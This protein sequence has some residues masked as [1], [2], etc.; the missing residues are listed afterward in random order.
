[1]NIVS[2]QYITI[3]GCEI[4]YRD[5]G[6]TGPVVLLT[7]GIGASLETWEAMLA[8]A[9]ESIRWIS[10]DIPG[11]GL[12]DFG[13]QPYG[14]S[15]FARFAWKLLDALDLKEPIVL[16]GNSLGAAISIHMAG[17]QPERVCKLGLLNAATLGRET[18][19]PFRLM[20]LPVLGALMTMPGKAAIDNQIKAIFLDS[21]AVSDEVKAIVKRNV[22]RPGAQKAFV[23]TLKQM[24]VFGGQMPSVVDRS[25]SILASLSCPVLFIHGREDAVIPCAH[26]VQAQAGTPDS[27][28]LVFEECGHTPQIE[29][30]R[31]TAKALID[32]ALSGPQ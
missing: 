9:D 12:S 10:W 3:Q 27:T 17:L 20:I 6:G 30:P 21:D 14:P 16:A 23:A 4:R 19:L 26:S 7:H 24:T 13:D 31:E 2:D 25:L 29:K 15:K 32:L 5:T 8:E 22:M 11:H 28:L 1:V 18:P